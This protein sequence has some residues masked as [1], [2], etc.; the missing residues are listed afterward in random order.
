MPT[1]NR[2]KKLKKSIASVLNQ[3]FKNLELII[4]DDGS[5]DNSKK[6]VMDLAKI[7]PRI[8]WIDG[9]HTGLPAVPRNNGINLAKGYYIAFI[10]SDDIWT[11]DKLETQLQHMINKNYYASCTN[12]VHKN[13]KSGINLLI[14]YNKKTLGIFDLLNDNKVITS[15]CMVSKNIIDR[16]GGFPTNTSFKAIEDYFLWLKVASKTDFLFINKPLVEYDS[17]ASD[18]IRKNVVGGEIQR[19]MV[20]VE[21]LKWSFKNPTLSFK[22]LKTIRHTFTLLYKK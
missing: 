16:L 5:T 8:R 22:Y 7:D 14:K 17:N 20:L 12:A 11:G 13:R 10:D 1:W 19:R 18:S 3:S 2:G 9:I 4:C 6:I 21:F 15:S